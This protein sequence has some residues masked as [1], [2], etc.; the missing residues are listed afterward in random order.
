MLLCE[1]HSGNTEPTREAKGELS[2]MGVSRRDF[3]KLSGAGI[4]TGALGAAGLSS[5]QAA[6]NEP[7]HTRGAKKSTTI[8]PYCSVGCGMIVE[9]L[10]GKLV[11]VE[12]DPDHPINRGALCPKGASVLQ[13]RDNPNRVL[14]PRY[15]AKG[16]AEWK[17]VEWDWALDEI[18][19]R[20]KSTRDATYENKAVWKSPDGEKEV[21]VNRTAAIASVGSAAMDNEECY[22]YQKF[23]R[24][25]GIVHIEHQA[26]L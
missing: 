24:G 20:V 14:K 6:G 5:A 16:A 22:L 3:L 1:G 12:G 18:S 15:R 11:N 17:E 25:L 8:C 21:T 26:R 13:L 9:T 19:K 4:A 23:L 7:L 10:D 2:A